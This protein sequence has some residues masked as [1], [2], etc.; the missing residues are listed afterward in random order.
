MDIGQPPLQTLI[1]IGEAKKVL[2]LFMIKHHV[3]LLVNKESEKSNDDNDN[4][5]DN[6][7]TNFNKYRR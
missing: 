4:N 3:N 6:V 2:V 1:E 5:N 7:A